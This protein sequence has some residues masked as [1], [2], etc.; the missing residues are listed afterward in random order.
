MSRRIVMAALRA[1]RR[2]APVHGILQLDVSAARRL[3]AEMQPPGSFTAFVVA[4][5]GRAAAA[6]PAVHAYRDW[7]GQVVTHNFVD[8]AALIEVER[9]DGPVP[10]AHLMR[11]ADVRSVADLTQ[12]IRAVQSSPMDTPSG[13]KLVRLL[14]TLGRIPGSLRLMYLAMALLPSVRRMSGTV[15]VTSVGM[16]GGGGGAVI[17]RPTLP[18]LDVLVGGLSERASV[19]DGRIVIREVLDL[20]IS[21]DHNLVDGAPAGRF[22]ADLRGRIEAPEA[23]LGEQV[24]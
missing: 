13:R 11:D 19:V 18:T 21:V 7:R 15:A 3:L 6:H 9:P 20:T 12:E 8:V 1:G 2:K 17:G 16:F 22:A 4:A 5:V 14:P 24:S 23:L 10:M